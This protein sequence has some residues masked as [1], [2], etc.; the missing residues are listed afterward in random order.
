MC[1]ASTCLNGG[2][3]QS[4]GNGTFFC[5]CPSGYFGTNCKTNFQNFLYLVITNY[6][7][8]KGNQMVSNPCSSNPCSNSGTCQ[9]YGSGYICSCPQFFSGLNCQTCNHKNEFILKHTT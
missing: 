1:T 2:T 8:I 9:S 7:L 4:S 3:C 5:Q 6:L